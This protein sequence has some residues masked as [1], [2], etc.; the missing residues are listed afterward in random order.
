MRLGI[1]LLLPLLHIRV[2]GMGLPVESLRPGKLLLDRS[3]N[4]RPLLIR[5]HYKDAS[6][7]ASFGPYPAR[8]GGVPAGLSLG[9]LI[10]RQ[11]SI[12]LRSAD[13]VTLAD[14]SQGLAQIHLYFLA[15]L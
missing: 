3:R 7:L 9:L 11:V 12:L 5:D 2:L 13:A 10:E 6:P 14:N 4:H 1:P 8:S 15:I